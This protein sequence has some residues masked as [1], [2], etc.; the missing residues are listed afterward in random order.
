MFV[1]EAFAQTGEGGLGAFGS[2]IPF[3]GIMAIMYFLLIRPQQKKAKLHRQMVASLRRGDSVETAGGLVARIVR[4]REGDEYVIAEI[5]KGVEVTLV[6]S[7][8]ARVITKSEPA[9]APAER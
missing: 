3:V 2:L 5:A 7:N 6:R 4:V 8:V 9:P 1:T